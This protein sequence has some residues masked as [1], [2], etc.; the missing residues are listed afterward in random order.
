MRKKSPRK[1]GRPRT[2]EPRRYVTVMVPVT[3]LLDLESAKQKR[4][5][6]RHALLV[7]AIESK[8]REILSSARRTKDVNEEEVKEEKEAA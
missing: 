5:C 8:V 7:E 4:K 3:T 2:A 1:I 6:T